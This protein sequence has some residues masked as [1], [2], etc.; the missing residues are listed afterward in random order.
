[1]KIE[2]I[3][4]IHF[5]FHRDNGKS[6]VN[7]LDS[8]DVDVLVIAGDLDLALNI[9]NSLKMFCDIY[10]KVVF[11]QGNH[12]YYSHGTMSNTEVELA[13]KEN[14]N[15]TWLNN[16]V[17]EIDGI[18]FIGGTLWFRDDP[19][20]VKYRVNMSDFLVIPNFLDWVY[21]ENAKTIE[22]FK[23]EMKEGDV[24][25]SH[26]LPTK[27]SISKIYKNDPLNPF[28]LCDI[29]DII[30]EKRPALYLHGHTHESMDYNIDNTRIVC[31]PL[32][33]P[34]MQNINYKK[35]TMDI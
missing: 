12:E 5:E 26:H 30:R 32:G 14:S 29:E 23:N 9:R 35:L 1:M 7:S 6:F 3:S 24:V 19:L 2:L 34:H 10:P 25:I 15:L 4:D 22:L 13:C 8:S 31:N 28:F 20:A 17:A 27:Q 18:R 16:N 11:V 21:L 33:Y